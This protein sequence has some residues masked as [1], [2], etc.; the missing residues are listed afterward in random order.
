MHEF[1]F[2]NVLLHLHEDLVIFLKSLNNTHREKLCFS[3][4]KTGINEN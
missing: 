1:Q 4:F 2:Q 3:E